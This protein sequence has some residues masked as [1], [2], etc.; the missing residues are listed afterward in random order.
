MRFAV[1]LSIIIYVSS[2]ALADT[3][4][5]FPS[6]PRIQQMCQDNKDLKKL[7]N[8]SELFETITLTCHQFVGSPSAVRIVPLARNVMSILR[9]L[10]GNLEPDDDVF[11]SDPKKQQ[12][13]AKLK[14]ALD[15]LAA[16]LTSEKR[17][18][19][20]AVTS[21]PLTNRLHDLL[22]RFGKTSQKAAAAKAK[23]PTEYRTQYLA[24]MMDT[25]KLTP[26]GR[27]AIACWESVR[28]DPFVGE[29]FVSPPTGVPGG[30]TAMF[31]ARDASM[32]NNL[33][34]IQERRYF[35]PPND[36]KRRYIKRIIFNPDSDPIETLHVLVHEMKHS[37]NVKADT[38]LRGQYLDQE[39]IVRRKQAECCPNN[40]ITP[41]CKTCF[42]AEQTKL[43]LIKKER[44][45][46]GIVDEC[47][48]YASQV[49]FYKEIAQADTGLV[50]NYH[51]TS[52]AFNNQVI[53][54]AQ[55]QSATEKMLRE[56]TLP[57][58]MGRDYSMTKGSSLLPENLFLDFKKGGPAPTQLRP[59]LIQKFRDAG[60]PIH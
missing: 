51:Y 55:F 19:S 34:S 54:S 23:N 57:L 35:A 7:E 48:A 43:D 15:Q 17:T 28:E 25:L 18:T 46:A 41:Q 3:N 31:V 1:I 59:E 50:C 4:S 53:S 11:Y 38:F 24:S 20:Q 13:K 5:L 37:C 12:E 2:S 52:G 29:E 60:C 8:L 22:D 16:A 9:N 30:I 32:P 26:E 36:G 58:L 49:Q 47:R 33:P 45:Q 10:P 40:E 14:E 21:N 56:G 44:D 6:E 39:E 27:K 42:Q